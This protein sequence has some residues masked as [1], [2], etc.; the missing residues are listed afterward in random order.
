MNLA[1]EQ[2]LIANVLL[3]QT[4]TIFLS[5]QHLITVSNYRLRKNHF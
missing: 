3:I 2:Q 1:T 4:S 5:L